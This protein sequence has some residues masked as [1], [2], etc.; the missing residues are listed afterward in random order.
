MAGESLIPLECLFLAMTARL[1]ISDFF[2]VA[3]P[4]R[5]SWDLLSE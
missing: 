4:V 3:Q 5:H 2:F 1:S